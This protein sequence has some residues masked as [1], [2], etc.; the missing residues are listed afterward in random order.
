MYIVENLEY[1]NNYIN[2]KPCFH[3]RL[4]S[5]SDIKKFA[6]TYN[7]VKKVFVSV[8]SGLPFKPQLTHVKVYCSP[9]YQKLV[10][11]FLDDIKSF[12]KNS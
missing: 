9:C 3:N 10:M 4:F 11:E 2:A 6:L 12:I 5:L 8:D 1:F 7:E